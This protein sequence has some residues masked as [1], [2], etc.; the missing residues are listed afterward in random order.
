M[1]ICCSSWNLVWQMTGNRPKGCRLQK[2]K[3]ALRLPA[4]FV[5]SKVGKALRETGVRHFAKIDASSNMQQQQATSNRQL[6]TVDSDSDWRTAVHTSQTKRNVKLECETCWQWECCCCCCCCCCSWTME[7]EL[8]L[9]LEL[10]A[11]LAVACKVA[12][13]FLPGSQAASEATVAA[14]QINWSIATMSTTAATSRVACCIR[15]RQSP[16]RSQSHRVGFGGH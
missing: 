5:R 12:S 4:Q 1:Y 6:A 7:L 16:S 13:Q 14:V 3:L 8:K 15:R 11:P 2:S 10:A 9:V